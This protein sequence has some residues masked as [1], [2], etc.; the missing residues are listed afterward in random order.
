MW[1]GGVYKLM[2]LFSKDALNLFQS[3]ENTLYFG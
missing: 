1:G 3:D 2:L